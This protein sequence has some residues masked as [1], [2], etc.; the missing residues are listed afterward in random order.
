VRLLRRISVEPFDGAAMETLESIAAALAAGQAPQLLAPD[1]PLQHLTAVH[2]DSKA[3]G[4]VL[5]GQSVTAD[6]CGTEGRARLY[7]PDGVLIGIGE[8]DGTGTVR[9]RRLFNLSGGW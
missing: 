7:E 4:K 8:A 2:L 1:A 3:T 9:P 6:G 5:H